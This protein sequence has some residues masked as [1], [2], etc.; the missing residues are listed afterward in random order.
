M[1]H[2]FHDV[3]TEVARV[4][5]RQRDVPPSCALVLRRL[6]NSRLVGSWPQPVRDSIIDAAESAAISNNPGPF[7]FLDRLVEKVL[8]PTHWPAHEL[9]FRLSLWAE[10]LTRK[11]Q[12][13]PHP[14]FFCARS[15]RTRSHFVE[16][17]LL[18]RKA[19]IWVCAKHAPG[20][21]GG[22]RAKKLAEWA[23]GIWELGATYRFISS[24]MRSGLIP[25]KA[26]TLSVTSI[27]DWKQSRNFFA[28]HIGKT[29]RLFAEHCDEDSSL[30]N[31]SC[32]PDPDIYGAARQQVEE[33][34]DVF[35][36]NNRREYGRLGGRPQIHQQEKICRA[37]TL[38]REGASLRAAAKSVG[39]SAATLSRRIK[40]PQ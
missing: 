16:P 3:E 32:G 39:L 7:L 21:A 15:S 25:L 36:A 40:K 10:S 29:I 24:Q 4:L 23:G 19:P 35:V 12:S 38:I 14:C 27:T 18:S 33:E 31:R 26:M 2:D 1:Q 9:A 22:R 34:Y 8:H 11:N 17:R 6:R 30:T 5:R 20:T 37:R 28:N 13:P